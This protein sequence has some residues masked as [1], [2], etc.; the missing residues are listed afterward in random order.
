MNRK[1]ALIT[2][3]GRG[4]GKQTLLPLLADGGRILQGSGISA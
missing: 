2:G 1:I 4:F 3:A